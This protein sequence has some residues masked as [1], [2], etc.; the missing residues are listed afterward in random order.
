MAKP[1]ISKPQLTLATVAGAKAVML[2]Y[3]FIRKN[4]G[5]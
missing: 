2:L 4:H 3:V 1:M 5:G